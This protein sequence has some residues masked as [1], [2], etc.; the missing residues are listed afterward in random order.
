MSVSVTLQ[1]VLSAVE[2]L[3]GN[4]P[5]ISAAKR[6]VTWDALSIKGVAMNAGSAVP[7]TKIAGGQVALANGAKTLDLTALAGLGANGTTVDFTGLKLQALYLENPA[8]NEYEISVAPG[9]A[10]G[11]AFSGADSKLTLAPGQS[12]LLYGA[13]EAPDVAAGAKTLDFAGTQAE[14]FNILLIAG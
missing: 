3:E 10:N 5:P 9:A 11:Y 13:D 14:A 1:Q 2:T 8:T 7:A 12:V 6:V 4:T